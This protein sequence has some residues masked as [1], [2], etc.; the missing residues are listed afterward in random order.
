MGLQKDPAVY[1]RHAFSIKTE[2]ENKM[3]KKM[4][5]SN[6]NHKKVNVSR[7][8][9]KKKTP[10]KPNCDSI[11]SDQDGYFMENRH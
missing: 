2:T 3:M 9:A 11:I 7:L 8:A 6:T 5:T 10:K 4:Y 1:K